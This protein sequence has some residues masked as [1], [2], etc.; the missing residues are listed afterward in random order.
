[1]LEDPHVATRSISLV[2]P[3][4]AGRTAPKSVAGMLN[5]LSAEG[6]ALVRF[7]PHSC[8][9]CGGRVHLRVQSVGVSGTTGGMRA[10]FAHAVDEGVGCPAVTPDACR[11]VDLGAAMF[12]GAQEGARHHLLKDMLLEAAS[13]DPEVTSAQTEV[14]LFNGIAVRRPDVVLGLGEELVCFDIQLAPPPR[15]TISGRTAFYESGGFHHVWVLDGAALEHD[16]GLQ[17]F[18]DLLWRQGGKVLAFDEESLEKTRAAS[19]LCFKLVAI[20][21]DGHRITPSWRW[22]SG[23]DLNVCFGLAPD[24]NGMA[25]DPIS[26][27]FF[28][29]LANR[30]RTVLQRW[31]VAMAADLAFPDWQAFVAD[32]MCSLIGALAT[33]LAGEVRDGSARPPSDVKAAVHNSLRTDTFDD[34]HLWAPLVRAILKARAERSPASAISRK[35]TEMIGRAMQDHDPV[36]FDRRLTRW[37]PLLLRLFPTI[38][39]P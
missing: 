38:R 14:S 27:A 8:G 15:V 32:G 37:R 18:Q 36:E 11:A 1:M 35:T 19:A 22:V 17:S 29:A 16:V 33:V 34:R 9:H 7:A 30:D 21:D 10:Y 20:R 26:H 24:A 6:L 2:R 13:A 5:S 39:L 28:E 3:L 23:P 31:Y 12:G 4:E 25:G